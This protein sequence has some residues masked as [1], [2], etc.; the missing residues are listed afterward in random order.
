M[1]RKIKLGTNAKVKGGFAKARK[2]KKLGG[3]PK[4]IASPPPTVLWGAMLL[5]QQK[6]KGK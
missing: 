2:T 6:R 1:P 4:P 5:G 3:P